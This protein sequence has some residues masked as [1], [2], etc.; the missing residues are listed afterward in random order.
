M[1]SKSHLLG[2][3]PLA[4]ASRSVA[5]VGMLLASL[6][7]LGQPV[8]RFADAVRAITTGESVL[9]DR[10][11]G[12]EPLPQL[13]EPTG[14]VLTLS[15]DSIVQR[16]ENVFF[17]R[18]NVR[19]TGRGYTITAEE[20]S[21]NRM[22][23]VVLASGDVLILADDQTITGQ[24]IE[25]DFR[26]Q[27]FRFTRALAVIG[28]SLLQGRLTDDLWIRGEFGFGSET[29]YEIFNG[30]V[31]TC[32]GCDPQYALAAEEIIVLVGRR[33]T[34]RNVRVQV[35]GRTIARIPSLVIPLD[36]ERGPDLPE[37]GQS[38]DEGFYVKSR[39]NVLVQ[40][41]NFLDAR[42]DGFSRLG[43]GF[44]LD[45]GYQEA[46][47]AGLITAY[48]IL[49]NT[50]T[51]R[52]TVDHEQGIGSA[53]VNLNSSF[54]GDD[55]LTAPG[56][57]IFNTRGQIVLPWGTGQSRLGYFRNDVTRP[58][59]SSSAET[60]TL[61][62]DRTFALGSG[63]IAQPLFSRQVPRGGV[64]GAFVRVFERL[65]IPLDTAAPASRSSRGRSPTLRI[66]SN[67][68]LNSSEFS[69]PGQ[70]GIRNEIFESR[71]NLAADLRTFTADLLYQRTQAIRDESGFRSQ[72][73]RLPLLT[74]RSDTTRLFGPDAGRR[75]P[76]QAEFSYGQ[77]LAPE[78]Q[79][80]KGRTTVDL[81]LRRTEGTFRNQFS[82][83]ARFRQFLY[84]DDTAQ[85]IT[86]LD[87]NYRLQGQG[88]TRV[89]L[90]YRYLRPEGF[91]PFISD[92]TG[93]FHQLTFDLGYEPHPDLFLTI[94]SG[95]DFLQANR[96]EVPWQ[97]L[98]FNAGWTPN[99]DFT[100]RANAA[101]DTRNQVWGNA[102]LDFDSFIGAT[103]VSGGVRFDGRRSTWSSANLYVEGFRSG[104]LT[105]SSL[106]DYNGFIGRIVTQ[107]HSLIWDLGC[108][109]AIL[110]FSDFRQGF[111][112]G[113][114]I[115]FFIR[116]KALPFAT[117]FGTG[118][119]GQSLG[120]G[121]TG[122]F[123]G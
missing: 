71:L 40:R 14:E 90:T 56:S 61:S 46:A 36:V 12:W 92:R 91:S 9:F 73:D 60:I 25:V 23:E 82:W 8:A 5:L 19:V 54:R 51:R 83:G 22:T 32:E 98:F 74:L 112:S 113:Q 15:A 122:G 7:L 48:G 29:R 47:A 96:G 68:S 80:T 119:R 11:Q 58:T 13:V 77:L 55:Y 95:Y 3:K 111:R 67:F 45:F 6:T 106:F 79:S 62:D 16:S 109:E 100:V 103:R 78:T 116:I 63:A 93:Q 17:L 66:S 84:S 104:R 107:Q 88:R 26:N 1:A 65:G 64:A 37:F 44:G 118:T 41:E 89:G 38:P 94:N 105:V 57:D 21:V 110:E 20:A 59:S 28:P 4:L 101:Y 18:G 115:G 50:A 102:R 108:T 120:F 30:I 35:L 10:T 75:F 117:P 49:G 76:L 43:G 123:G 27:T 114:Q 39:F 70:V 121:G 31:T 99:R 34:L 97:Q 53:R 86:N 24:E 42:L 2:G 87:A 81:N 69:A 72:Q 52:F 85:Y 33:I